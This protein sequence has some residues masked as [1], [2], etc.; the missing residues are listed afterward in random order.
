M[1]TVY[2][3]NMQ[4]GMPTMWLYAFILKCEILWMET[5][6]YFSLSWETFNMKLSDHFNIWRENTFIKTSSKTA[7]TFKLWE[8]MFLKHYLLCTLVWTL[9]QLETSSEQPT[10]PWQLWSLRP[11]AQTFKHSQTRM[12]ELVFSGIC[13]ML[14]NKCLF[15]CLSFVSGAD[16]VFHLKLFLFFPHLKQKKIWK[17]WR[18]LSWRW[19]S[20]SC[21]TWFCN[22]FSVVFS[23]MWFVVLSPLSFCACFEGLCLDYWLLWKHCQIDILFF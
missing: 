23:N 18:K 6:F 4:W 20:F 22:N 19:V 3:A 12:K 9:M 11:V 10:E 2:S 5:C 8:Q 15:V 7:E 16:L 17:S 21:F 13:G 1:H 14:Y